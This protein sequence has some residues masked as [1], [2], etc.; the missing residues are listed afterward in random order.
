MKNKISVL[1]CTYNNK[2]YVKNCIES[3]LKQSE[4][5][6]EILCIDG[7]SSDGTLDLVKSYSKKDKRV[8]LIIN[9]NRL[10]E[11]RGNG[12]WLGF[13]K[14]NGEVVAIIDQDNILQNK[15][16]F[17]DAYLSL[18]DEKNSF[19][20]LGALTHDFK[21]NLVTRYI[22]LFGTDSFFAFKSVDYLR[23]FKKIEKRHYYQLLKFSKSNPW[24]T[25]GNCF[26]YRRKDIVS[27]GG[28]DRDVSSVNNLVKSGKIDLIIIPDSTKHYA[29]TSFPNLIKKKFKWGRN[30]FSHKS[31]NKEF[32]YTSSKKGNILLLMNTLFSLTLVPNLLISLYLLMK[33]RDFVVLMFPIIAFLNTIAYAYEFARFEI[34][35]LLQ[36]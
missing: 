27:I 14:A 11:G 10:P 8:K 12:K 22:S 33:K 6:F 29:E 26:F 9:K 5:S 25:G 1:L 2:Q 16:L 7:G 17:R 32:S 30:F 15:D 24:I 23:F 18:R 35:T 28:Y 20:V 3:I 19:G 36:K 13:K 34:S 31:K 21:D 4:R